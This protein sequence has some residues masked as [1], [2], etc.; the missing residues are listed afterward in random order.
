[1]IRNPSSAGQNKYLAL[2]LAS[3]VSIALHLA[4]WLA[5][6]T[7]PVKPAPIETPPQVIEVTLVA[8]PSV[9]QPPVATPKPETPAEQPK[10]KPIKPKPKLPPKPS[11]KPKPLIKPVRQSVPPEPV[12]TNTAADPASKPII[13]AQSNVTAKSA[14]PSTPVQEPLV[15]AIYSSPS[16]KNPPTHYPRIAQVRQWE[17]T[18]I[19][20]I[21]VFAN[22]SAGDIKIARS[23]GHE[24]LDDSAVE[25]VKSWHFIPA[26]K[27]EKTVDDWVRVP[28][29]F[30]FKH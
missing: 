12:K 2:L 23:S 20:E 7:D 27:G 25:Q 19:L 10:Q 26:H 4:S 9:K 22:G 6:Q 8:P 15:K 13:T 14:Q 16:L 3:A 1:M 5:W 21:R 28:I 24:I 29:T 11:P 18:V 30:K 17:G